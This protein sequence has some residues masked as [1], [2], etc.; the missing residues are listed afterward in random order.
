M[1]R[2][3]TLSHFLI[4]VANAI[5]SKTGRNSSIPALDQDIRKEELL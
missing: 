4:D 3:D 2:I 5:R 1:A